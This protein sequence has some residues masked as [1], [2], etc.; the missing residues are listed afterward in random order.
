MVPSVELA[1]AGHGLSASRASAGF[2]RPLR[3]PRIEPV[4]PC[5]GVIERQGNVVDF[6]DHAGL[7]PRQDIQK[8]DR[9]IRI[10][11]DAMRIVD[12]QDVAGAKL[13]EQG[14]VDTLQRFHD[15]ADRRYLQFRALG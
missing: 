15:L 2:S 10:H 7:Q 4:R 14:Q 5:R 1:M 6:D 11:Q 13:I 9:G 8:Y 3:P 12:K